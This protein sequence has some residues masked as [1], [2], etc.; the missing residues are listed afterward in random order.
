MARLIQDLEVQ[1][2][3][4]AKN[5]QFEKAAAIARSGRGAEEDAGG[6]GAA[7]PR[8]VAD[9]FREGHRRFGQR[10]DQRAAQFRPEACESSIR[11]TE[12]LAAGTN[13]GSQLVAADA[14]AILARLARRQATENR[15]L[16][17]DACHS[18]RSSSRAPA[19]TT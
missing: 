2:R 7:G 1:M 5:L 6:R 18:I 17:A 9:E 13:Q 4:A 11:R 12:K 10:F 15:P 19:S 8:Q 16:R 14:T 3:Q